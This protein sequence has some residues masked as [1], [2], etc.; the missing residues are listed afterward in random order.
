M[1]SDTKGCNGGFDFLR[2]SK[3]IKGVLNL[4]QRG[5]SSGQE[6]GTQRTSK[7]RSRGMKLSAAYLAVATTSGMLCPIC[8]LV[9]GRLSLP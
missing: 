7:A 6:N 3:G 2:V 9:G 8:I 4:E 5:Q 1:I